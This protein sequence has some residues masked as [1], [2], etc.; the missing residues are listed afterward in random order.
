MKAEVIKDVLAPRFGSSGLG[1][2]S[3]VNH[4]PTGT[5]PDHRDQQ[6]ISV[7]SKLGEQRERPRFIDPDH[8]PSLSL[9]L[10]LFPSFFL[11]FSSSISPPFALYLPLSLFFLSSPCW[12][13]SIPAESSLSLLSSSPMAPTA[14]NAIITIIAMDHRI[15]HFAMCTRSIVEECQAN[16]P[17]WF[18]QARVG[19]RQFFFLI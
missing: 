18:T 17:N 1:S 7:V 6:C 11:P 10:T 9:Y 2:G 8:C 19:K 12:V 5:T 3:P 16:R 4:W 15:H 13:L 14:F